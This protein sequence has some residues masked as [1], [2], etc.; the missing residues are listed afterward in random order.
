M[1]SG[2]TTCG[3]KLLY[4]LIDNA[5]SVKDNIDCSNGSGWTIDGANIHEFVFESKNTWAVCTSFRQYNFQGVIDPFKLGEQVKL[6]AG[7]NVYR[8]IDSS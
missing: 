2:T 3:T 6:I 8:T 5:A 7:F 1:W 4:K